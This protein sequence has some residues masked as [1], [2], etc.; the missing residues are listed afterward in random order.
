[1]A[2]MIRADEIETPEFRLIERD[3][4]D[5]MANY[6]RLLP[7]GNIEVRTLYRYGKPVVAEYTP[8]AFDAWREQLD[9]ALEL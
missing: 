1:M 7:T 4:Q 3:W 9:N 6:A 5:N 2:R 8:E